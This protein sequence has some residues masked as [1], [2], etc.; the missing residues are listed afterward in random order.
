MAFFI[1]IFSFYEVKQLM[2]AFRPINK[3]TTRK[4]LGELLS[5]AEIFL[6]QDESVH[7]INL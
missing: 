6:I 1:Y 3:K 4:I 2:N 7:V 5:S